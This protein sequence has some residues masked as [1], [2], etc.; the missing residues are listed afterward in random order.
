MLRANHAVR[1][2]LRAASRNPELSFA[3]ALLDQGGTLLSL[4]PVLLAAA[5]IAGALGDGAPLAALARLLGAARALAFPLAGGVLTAAAL[6]WTTSAFFWSG[7]LPLLA[8]DAEMDARPPRGNFLRLAS[9]GFSRVASASAL[10]SLLSLGVAV[11]F[12]AA[13]VVAAPV[14]AARPSPALLAGAALAAATSIVAGVLI[15][16]LARLMLVRAAALG[17][18]AAAA[19]HRAATLLS[20]R[21][22][23]CLAIALAFLVLELVVATAGATLSGTLSTR[24]DGAHELV[25][26][27]PRIAVGLATAVVFAWLEVG[28][29]GALAALA[30]GE[31]GLIEMPP[32]PVR[33]APAPAVLLRPEHVVEALPVEEE[34]RPPGSTRAAEG[35]PVVEALPVDDEEQR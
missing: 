25:A 11:A 22:G 32:E 13:F 18:G 29:Q 21:L 27:A 8:A 15:D 7:A 26:L 20:S 1:L 28:R 17:D 9:R 33:P 24:L 30:A 23:A 35:E 4:L 3:K 16:L 34:P 31:E 5:L 19:F 2:G 6:A 12:A 10:G 14:V